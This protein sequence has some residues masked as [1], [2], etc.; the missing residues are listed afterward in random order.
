[1]SSYELSVNLPPELQM[2]TTFLILDSQWTCQEVPSQYKG[3]KQKITINIPFELPNV[4][5]HFWAIT[6][7]G[8]LRGFT[9]WSQHFSFEN[10]AK[11][12]SKKQ[13]VLKIDDSYGWF[14]SF[15]KCAHFQQHA[16]VLALSLSSFSMS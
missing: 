6:D 10:Q 1:M 11:V 14:F 13:W 3:Q 16:R 8:H 5:G 4:P 2:A 9:T 12:K 15:P 7:M